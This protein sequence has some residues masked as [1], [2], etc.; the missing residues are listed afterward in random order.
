MVLTSGVYFFSSIIL[1]NNADLTLAP[2]AEVTIYVDGDVELKNSSSVN[3]GGA[4]ADLMIYSSGDFVLKN[5]GDISAVFYSPDG[6]GDL[7]N[8]GEFFGSII[9]N[10]IVAHN[11]A[12]FHYDRMLADISMGKS[13]DV[14]VVG[15]QEL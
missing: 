6:T 3:V 7:R 15:W 14:Y 5:S 1:K 12:N 2:G 10:D 4:P 9:T 11:S 13:S 8:S